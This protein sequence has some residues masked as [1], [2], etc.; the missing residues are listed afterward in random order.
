MRT[1]MSRTAAAVKICNPLVSS[2]WA[3]AELIVD[4]RSTYAWIRREM[5]ETIGAEPSV[6]WKLKIYRER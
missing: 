6:A 1:A 5:L 2:K 4:A 3:E